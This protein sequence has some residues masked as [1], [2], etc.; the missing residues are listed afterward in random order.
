M[1]GPGGG[2][3]VSLDRFDIIKAVPTITWQNPADIDYGTPLGC[4]AA[5]RHGERAWHLHIHAAGRHG[6]S[7]GQNQTLSVQFTPT[8]SAD[9]Y[10]AAASVSINVNKTDPQIEWD[11]I[12]SIFY[13]Q[14]L[15]TT[16]LTD[17]ERAGHV[18]L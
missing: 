11:D 6:A 2:T 1:P 9:Y 7:A 8:D 16:Q 18:R 10:P 15:T 12:E 13:G 17:G 4:D 3:T 14:P 5:R